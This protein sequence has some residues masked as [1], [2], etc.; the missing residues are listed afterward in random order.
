MTQYT[1]QKDR[2][3]NTIVCRGDTARSGYRIIFVG[4]YSECLTAAGK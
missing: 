4:T 3:G 2:N 1:A